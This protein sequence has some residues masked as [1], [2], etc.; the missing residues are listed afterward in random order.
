MIARAFKRFENGAT[1]SLAYF[2]DVSATL[3]DE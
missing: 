1:D 3:Q 2:Y